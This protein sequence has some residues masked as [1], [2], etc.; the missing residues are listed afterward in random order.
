MNPAYAV[1]STLVNGVAGHTIYGVVRRPGGANMT[2]APV[3]AVFDPEFCDA[4]SDVG[5]ISIAPATQD[6]ERVRVSS[7]STLETV[8]PQSPNRPNAPPLL[9]STLSSG[10]AASGS[11]SM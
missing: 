3:E 8:I 4:L 11:G 10:K 9:I 5:L 6:A 1:A 2:K 7:L